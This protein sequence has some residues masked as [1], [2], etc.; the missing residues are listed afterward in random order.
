MNVCDIIHML[1][2]ICMDSEKV[3]L[4]ACL[5]FPTTATHVALALKKQKIGAG[6]L[7]GV[8]GGI[9]EGESALQCA[10]REAQEEWGI[11]FDPETL[12]KKGVVDF[13]NRKSDGETFVCR[14]HIFL[15]P[16]WEGAVVES[17]EMGVPQWF[18]KDNIPLERMML[19]DRDW[20]PVC[21]TTDDYFYAEAWYGPKQHT[22]EQHTVLKLISKEK[23]EQLV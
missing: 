13:H 7:N 10:V 8:G 16:P 22:L 15:S 19:A 18:Q 4:R 21:V 5:V 6:C 11:S 9:E 3:L 14:V 23:L 20:F 12:T 1:Y 2:T 17:E